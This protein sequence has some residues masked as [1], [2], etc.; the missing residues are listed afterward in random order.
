MERLEELEL[1]T[2]LALATLSDEEKGIYLIMLTGLQ[3][4]QDNRIEEA[5][6]L[7]SGLAAMGVTE[8]T[9]RRLWK[10]TTDLAKVSGLDLE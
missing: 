9:L 7:R 1:A 2:I 10:L 6:A 4:M 5:K 3:L 8:D